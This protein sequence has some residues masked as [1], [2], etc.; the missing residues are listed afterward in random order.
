MLALKILGWILLLMI[1]IPLIIMVV[2]VI[3]YGLLYLEH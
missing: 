2:A 1:L 3:F